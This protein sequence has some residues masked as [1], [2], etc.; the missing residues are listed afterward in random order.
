[1]LHVLAYA[2][3]VVV[4]LVPLWLLGGWLRRKGKELERNKREP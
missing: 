2:A 1:M 3:F 4:F